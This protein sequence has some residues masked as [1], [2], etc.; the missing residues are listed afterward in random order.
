MPA[1]NWNKRQPH[2]SYFKEKRR[3]RLKTKERHFFRQNF[4]L[5]E[6]EKYAQGGIKCIWNSTG[7]KPTHQWDCN[8]YMNSRNKGSL[9][10]FH[11]Y[12]RG[13][14]NLG[15]MEILVGW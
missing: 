8:F 4:A 10:C 3:H 13:I 11:E 9:K 7:V 12:K 14:Q 5:K 2:H 1:Y 15:W 6:E